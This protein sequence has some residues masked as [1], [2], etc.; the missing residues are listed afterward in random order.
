MLDRWGNTLGVASNS[1]GR[2]LASES[3]FISNQQ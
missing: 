2:I 1:A 3:I